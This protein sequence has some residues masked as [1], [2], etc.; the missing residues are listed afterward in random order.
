[1][2]EFIEPI[3]FFYYNPHINFI[4]SKSAGLYDFKSKGGDI[5]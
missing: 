4:N 5:H 1:M 3:K 2:G